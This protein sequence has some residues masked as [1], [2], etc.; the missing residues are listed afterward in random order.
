VAAS[1]ATSGELLEI[2]TDESDHNGPYLCMLAH[3]VVN[4]DS[5]DAAA[6]VSAVSADELHT[7]TLPAGT[8]A[9]FTS[10]RDPLVTVAQQEIWAM[11][12]AQLGGER[13]YTA[14]FEIFG[15]NPA[16]PEDGQVDIYVAIT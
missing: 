16:N 14:D 5:L 3:P 1:P 4:P 6:E 13:R 10:A 7:R 11:D 9:V 2:Y 12:A 8:Y 15:E